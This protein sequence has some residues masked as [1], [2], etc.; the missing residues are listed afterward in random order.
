MAISN[1]ETIGLAEQFNQFL[2]QHKAF[3]QEKGLNVGNW[4]TEGGELKHDAVTQLN[5]QDELDAA[6]RAQTPVTQASVKKL[7][8]T[9][10]TR[11]DATIG[12]IGKNTPLAKELGRMR[13]RIIRQYRKKTD[14]SDEG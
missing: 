1:T 6:S 11:I 4:I 5:R 2:E 13:S 3:L 10:S 8:D 9:T 7:Y 14:G 12:V